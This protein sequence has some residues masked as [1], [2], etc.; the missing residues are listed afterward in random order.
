M[1]KYV[2]TDPDGST[3]RGEKLEPG[4]LIED[5]RSGKD[6]LARLGACCCDS[7]LVAALVSPLATADGARMFQI[8]CWK[9]SADSD[10]AQMY[11]V[12][13]EVT[14]VPQVTPGQKLAFALLVLLQA[15]KN[16]DFQVWAHGWLS[17]ED[18]S[19]NAA[20]TMRRLAEHEL[21]AA[22]GLEVLAAWGEAGGSDTETAKDMDRLAHGVLHAARAAEL[23][24][25]SRPD[26]RQAVE[27]LAQ[28]FTAIMQY[29]G[30]VD[31]AA[32][33]E[34]ATGRGDAAAPNAA[35]KA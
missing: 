19:S 12:V 6:L 30:R 31:L 2:L 5:A 21:E 34:K 17:G 16:K 18:R 26:V 11:T 7:P 22:D 28:A 25:L 4:K 24:S 27:A 32:L 35:S 29:A 23:M 3:S 15:Y 10:Q 14:P 20:Q 8:N 9:V 33:A 13:K 1:R